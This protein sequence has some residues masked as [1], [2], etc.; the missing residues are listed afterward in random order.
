[1]PPQLRF[2]YVPLY[3]IPPLF[4]LYFGMEDEGVE[5]LPSGGRT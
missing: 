5:H 1:M 2:I 4:R 3:R